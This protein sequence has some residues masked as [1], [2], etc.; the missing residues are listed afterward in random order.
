MPPERDA[1]HL[2]ACCKNAT[3]ARLVREGATRV[4]PQGCVKR[5]CKVSTSELITAHKLSES[6]S[7]QVAV[8]AV[9]VAVGWR[10]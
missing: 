4:P 2:T 1:I 8:A 6:A 5:E 10:A 7:G 3:A 9:M